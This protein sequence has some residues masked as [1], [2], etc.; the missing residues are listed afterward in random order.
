MA[1][2]IGITEEL[3]V[4]KIYHIRGQKVKLDRDL[5]E[6]Y[7]VETRRLKEQVKRNI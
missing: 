3:I 1:K 4:N 6:M 5:A 7:G 2:S